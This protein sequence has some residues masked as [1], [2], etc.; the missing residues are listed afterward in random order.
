MSINLVFKEKGKQ[1]V[2]IKGT[3]DMPFSELIQKYFKNIC[4]SKKDKLTKIFHVKGKET[5]PEDSQKLS[6]LG[7][8]D[9]GEI[10]IGSTEKAV[11][12]TA[13]KKEE[14][15]PEPPAQEPPAEEPPAEEPPAEEPPAEEQPPAEEPPAE[16][17]P[18]ENNEDW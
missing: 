1:N 5:S 8:K 18:E 3:A 12:F 15:K 16:Q 4:A 7:L 10:D 11:T 6:E 14:P 13:A 2:I 9:F 17:P